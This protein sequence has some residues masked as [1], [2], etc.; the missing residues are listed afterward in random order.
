MS[1]FTQRSYCCIGNPLVISLAVISAIVSGGDATSTQKKGRPIPR[2]PVEETSLFVACSEQGEVLYS[3]RLLQLGV[4][5]AKGKSTKQLNLTGYNALHCAFSSNGKYWIAVGGDE[6]DLRDG[7]NGK[8]QTT[9]KAQGG[10]IAA[11]SIG[12]CTFLELI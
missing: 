8:I 5:D 10:R 12:D 11:V 6:A 9:I 7:A 3:S 4:F 1:L 2:G